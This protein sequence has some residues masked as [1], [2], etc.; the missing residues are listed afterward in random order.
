MSVTLNVEL[1]DVLDFLDDL[2]DEAQDNLTSYEEFDG[3]K[4]QLAD[5][6]KMEPFDAFLYGVANGKRDQLEFIKALVES[7]VEEID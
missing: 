6:R 2:L 3:D 5:F 1:D 4:F 7:K